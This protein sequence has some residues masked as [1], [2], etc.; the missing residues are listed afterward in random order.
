MYQYYYKN[1]FFPKG[2]VINNKYL[3]FPEKAY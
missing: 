3:E 1:Y 2:V